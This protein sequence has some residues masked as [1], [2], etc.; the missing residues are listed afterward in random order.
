MGLKHREVKQLAY[1]HKLWSF[2]LQN[3]GIFLVLFCLPCQHNWFLASLCCFARGILVNLINLTWTSCRSC[4]QML[5]I[6]FY[7][8][9]SSNCFL[10]SGAM[11]SPAAVTTA[12]MSLQPL[13]GSCLTR[14][15]ICKWNHSSGPDPSGAGGK[16]LGSLY[17]AIRPAHLFSILLIL[18]LPWNFSGSA[19]WPPG[20]YPIP[21]DGDE[22]KSWT[23]SITQSLDAFSMLTRGLTMEERRKNGLWTQLD[24]SINLS[25][26][27]VRGP[28]MVRSLHFSEPSSLVYKTETVILTSSG[29]CRD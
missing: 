23:G 11:P 9:S 26:A 27:L 12:W 10:F 25:P 6:N 1:G 5:N 13:L 15:V 4:S 29:S 19:L 14:L 2:W 24:S 28:S 17:P 7:E 22:K 21:R 16:H 20:R 8:M 18:Q 3:S